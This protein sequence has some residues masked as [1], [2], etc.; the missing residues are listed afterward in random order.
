M[1]Y[2]QWCI[3][4]LFLLVLVLPWCVATILT[5]VY[6]EVFAATPNP[7]NNQDEN[8]S[9]ESTGTMVISIIQ[10]CSMVGYILYIFFAMACIGFVGRR[11][12]CSYCC[13]V[14]GIPTFTVIPVAAGSTLLVL[15]LGS[16]SEKQAGVNIGVA[17]AVSCLLSTTLCIV[18]TCWALICGSRGRGKNHR[19]PIPLAYLPFL[20]DFKKD[21]VNVEVSDIERHTADYPPPLSSFNDRKSVSVDRFA[22]PSKSSGSRVSSKQN[23]PGDKVWS[24]EGQR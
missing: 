20:R 5:W 14:V 21:A 10:T 18:I 1:N 9:A 7:T 12:L 16:P 17:A 13:L 11:S 24:K 2:V 15:A 22:T 3:W 8:G 6:S 23:K 19:F 4:C